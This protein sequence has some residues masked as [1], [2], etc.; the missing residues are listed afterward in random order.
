MK[1]S[2]NLFA[3]TDQKDVYRPALAGIFHTIDSQTKKG[4]AV[5][6]DT[7]ILIVSEAAYKPE[8]QGKIELKDGEPY[9]VGET[10]TVPDWRNRKATQEVKI[11][12]PK[13]ESVIPNIKRDYMSVP[14]SLFVDA[15]R[16]AQNFAKNAPDTFGDGSKIKRGQRTIRTRVMVNGKDGQDHPIYIDTKYLEKFLD[17]IGEDGKVFVYSNIYGYGHR[18]IYGESQNNEIRALL[19]PL[20]SPDSRVL[21]ELDQKGIATDADNKDGLYLGVVWTANLPYRS[22]ESAR[23]YATPEKKE[24][25]PQA[26]VIRPRR[27]YARMDQGRAVVNLMPAAELQKVE[28]METMFSLRAEIAK[29]FRDRPEIYKYENGYFV[30]L[31]TMPSTLSANDIALLKEAD[32]LTIEGLMKAKNW[33]EGPVFETYFKRTRKAA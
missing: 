11:L 24:R 31:G 5:A 18:A 19:M 21:D 25:V 27:G 4:V 23:L 8:L 3:Y 12:Y 29:N 7:H 33:E 28:G 2:I 30:Y 14:V 1:K 13:W 10:C 15:L 6:T 16:C 32:S 20:T 9:T 22:E 17:A 26:K